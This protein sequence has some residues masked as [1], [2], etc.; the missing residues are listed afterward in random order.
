MSFAVGACIMIGTCVCV[1]L[2]F[3]PSL[4]AILPFLGPPATEK[5]GRRSADE[6]QKGRVHE[7]DPRAKALPH[8]QGLSFFMGGKLTGFPLNLI[9]AIVVYSAMFPLSK[10]FAQNFDFQQFKFKLGHS[11]ANQIP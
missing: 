9:V 11:Y 6:L 4:L 8:M 1:Q 7:S 10:R 3:T 2:T 5:K